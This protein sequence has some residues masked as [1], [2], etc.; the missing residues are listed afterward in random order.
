MANNAKLP[1]FKT[2]IQAGID[3]KTKLPL[4]MGQSPEQLKENEKKLLR[5]LDEQEAINR[6]VWYNLPSGLTSQQLER[7]LYYKYSLMFFFKDTDK[8]G[9]F[10]CLPYALDGDID[11][12]GRFNKVTPC[13]FGGP[14]KTDKDDVWIEGLNFNVVKEVALDFN[15]VAD[16]YENGCVLIR[17]YTQQYGE[18]G[19]SRQVLQ[20]SL[21][22]TL[23]EAI[24]L[25]RTNMIA[26]S[27]VT[28]MRVNDESAV[29]NVMAANQS[30]EHAALSGQYLIPISSPIEFQDITNK[31]RASLSQDFMVYLEALNN[32]RL[33]FLG[34]DST[35][36]YQ[37]ST[38][39]NQVQSANANTA[40]SLV[41]ND[42]LL[43]RQRACDLINSIWGLGVWC[44]LNESLIGDINMD[45][46]P[47]E[48]LDQ[49]GIAN[50]Q[51]IGQV[52][53]VT[54]NE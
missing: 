18:L 8:G 27:G 54:E 50:D 26:N 38:Y 1:D 41:L 42:G 9:E 15:E 2:Y 39:V 46:V 25:A 44:T 28:A 53:E 16:N 7:M 29:P 37:K 33:S 40:I 23:A 34:I 51:P 52:N 20:D 35:G 49:S 48:Q 17:D 12:Y 13:I 4:K 45:G 30:I 10:F 19:I 43:Q 11:V 5:I 6:Y 22:D 24:P 21:I 47:L 3:P 14:G 32:H 36:T 31:G